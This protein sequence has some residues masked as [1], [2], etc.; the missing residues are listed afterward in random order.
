MKIIKENCK[1]YVVGD[2]GERAEIPFVTDD[3]IDGLT[4]DKELKTSQMF[5]AIKIGCRKWEAKMGDAAFR[6]TEPKEAA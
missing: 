5:R 6:N 4:L 3:D 2:K 1:F